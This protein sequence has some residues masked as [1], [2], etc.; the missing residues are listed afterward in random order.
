[1]CMEV[2]ER[3]AAEGVKAR[4]VSMP[5][6]ELFERQD[7]EYRDS[8]LP[9]HV[10]ARV[11][12][13]AGVKQGWDRYA[14]PDGAIVGM[15]SFGTSAPLKDVMAHFGFTTDNVVAVAKQQLVTTG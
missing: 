8:V 4:V 15:E 7:P 14:G 2:R 13:E 3:L 6:W 12:V 11:A 5:S 9:P 10:K 1:L